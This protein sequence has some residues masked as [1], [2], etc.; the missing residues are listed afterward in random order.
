MFSHHH[1]RIIKSFSPTLLPS[2]NIGGVQGEQ[3]CRINFLKKVSLDS[4]KTLS[5]QIIA[6]SPR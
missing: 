6:L 1:F 4:S 3:S 2:K 5:E